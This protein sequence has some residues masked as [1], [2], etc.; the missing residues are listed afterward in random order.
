MKKII[1]LVVVGISLMSCDMVYDY[2]A[3]QTMQEKLSNKSLY[4]DY[5]LTTILVNLPD[6]SIY[7]NDIV[8][9]IEDDKDYAQN[10]EETYLIGAGDC[11]DFAIL[12]MNIAY[13]EFGIKC[14]L[15]LVNSDKTIENGGSLNH[16][17]IRYEGTLYEPQTGEIC[18]YEVAY[19]YT[20]DI[21]FN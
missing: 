9:Y 15:V 8:S 12:F 17:L 20:F 14:D 6:I 10:P 3:D 21:I 16:A 1:L 5:E 11:E 4:E 2:A 7:M 13:F 19:S 18:S